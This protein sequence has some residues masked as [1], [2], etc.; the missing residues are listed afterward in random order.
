MVCAS[1]ERLHAMLW[2]ERVPSHSNPADRPSR[3]VEPEGSFAHR[4]EV[5]ASLPK[6]LITDSLVPDAKV[7]G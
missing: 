5:D 3:G 6:K 7:K 2:Y 1:E 4:L